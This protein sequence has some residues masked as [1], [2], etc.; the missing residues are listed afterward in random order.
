MKLVLKENF[1]PFFS[2]KKNPT[3]EERLDLKT[4]T[5]KGTPLSPFKCVR[6]R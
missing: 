1:V 3:K 6:V 4:N 2:L 5:E